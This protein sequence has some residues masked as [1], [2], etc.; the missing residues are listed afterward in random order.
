MIYLFLISVLSIST[1]KCQYVPLTASENYSKELAVS[2]T[3][4]K[5]FWKTLSGS[6]IQF[7]IHVRATGW[8]AL[9]LSRSGGM[10]GIITTE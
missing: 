5:M 10:N 3:Q 8:I 2:G 7:E 4:Y 1:I 9:G 6:E